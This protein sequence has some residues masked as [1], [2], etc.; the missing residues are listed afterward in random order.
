MPDPPIDDDVTPD[1]LDNEV[2]AE[3]ES[4]SSGTARVVARHLVMA[5]RLLDD[6]VEAAYEHAMAARRRAT[7]LGV[8]REAAGIAAYRSGR[9]AEAL[10][11]LRTVRRMTGSA[12]YLPMMADCERGLGR[13]ERALDLAGDPAI[14]GLGIA[15]RMEMLIVA[16]GA[17]RDLG[18]DAAAA[19]LLQVPEL[20]S[21]ANEG[22]VA[23]LRYAYADALE[24]AG[25]E[26]EARR[27]F[28]RAAEADVDEETDAAER[29][30]ASDGS[31]VATAS[32]GSEVEPEAGP[33]A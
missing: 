15:A 19:A 6:D 28:I 7:R 32:D 20:R 23:R 30:A 31:E 18:Q 14:T 1:E 17:R 33:D 10:A 16:A 4:L 3:L 5:G 13:P 25:R 12:E 11:E 2:L 24:A 8:V 9:Y 22:W 27:W 26:K 21:A 29:A